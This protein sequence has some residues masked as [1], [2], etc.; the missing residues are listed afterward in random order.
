MSAAERN[1]MERVGPKLGLD[2]E[3]IGPDLVSMGWEELR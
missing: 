3:R 1:V 2:V